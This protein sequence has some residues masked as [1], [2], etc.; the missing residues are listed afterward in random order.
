MRPDEASLPHGHIALLKTQDMAY[1]NHA[2]AKD[3]HKA[4]KLQASL[5][6]LRDNG[7][8]APNTHTVF[9]DSEVGS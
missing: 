9:V 4:H 8:D 5:H 3:T 2:R 1:I 6:F 7:E